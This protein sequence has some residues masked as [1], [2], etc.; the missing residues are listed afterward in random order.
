MRAAGVS[1]N[2]EDGSPRNEESCTV[3]SQ[4]QVGEVPPA[5]HVTLVYTCP[6]TREDLEFYADKLAA[7]QD[8]ADPFDSYE[9]SGCRI[10]SDADGSCEVTYYYPDG[11]V[12]SAEI[13]VTLNE[14][15]S[16]AN[17]EQED[18]SCF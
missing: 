8:P 6:L 15:A 2:F 12:C 17:T 4:T 3:I 16:V 7:E 5:T 14:D 18:V 1:M 10:I 11:A 9:V 13:V